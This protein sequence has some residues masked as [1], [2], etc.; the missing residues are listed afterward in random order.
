MA[1]FEFDDPSVADKYLTLLWSLDGTQPCAEDPDKWT[2][3]WTGR[4]IPDSVAEDMCAGCPFIVECDAYATAAGEETG[5]WGGR[6]PEMRRRD[7]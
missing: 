6:S 4:P 5:I 7:G 2:E 1:I 3:N